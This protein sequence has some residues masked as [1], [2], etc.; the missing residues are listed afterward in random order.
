MHHPR[1]L[2]AVGLA[3]AG[4]LFGSLT[5]SGCSSNPGG[6]DKIVYSSPEEVNQ[7]KADLQDAMK[8]GAY[9]SAGKRSR[10]AP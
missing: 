5:S 6:G 1:S 7:K 9:G 4:G 2:A 8:G 10:L 3:L